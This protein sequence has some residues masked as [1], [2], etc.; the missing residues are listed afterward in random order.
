MARLCT[1]LVHQK[2]AT[3]QFPKAW[4]ERRE[5]PIACGWHFGSLP[6]RMW[7]VIVERNAMPSLIG[8]W[9]LV[10]THAFDDAGQEV[11]SPLGP[12]PMGVGIIDAERIMVVGGDGCTALPPEAKRTFV[13]Y[14]GRYTFDGTKL[15]TRVDGASSPEMMEDQIRHIRFDGSRRMIAVPISRLFGRGGGLELVWERCAPVA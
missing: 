10:E 9:K 4:C 6:H 3:L 11:P 15:V 7:L 1:G 13:A 5:I 14:C 8:V 12:H 2:S